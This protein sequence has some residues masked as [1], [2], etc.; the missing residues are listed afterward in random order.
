MPRHKI[1]LALLAALAAG[2]ASST[3]TPPPAEKKDD[4][5]LRTARLEAEE[6]SRGRKQAEAQLED[7][8]RELDR[9]KKELAASRDTSSATQSEA[10][11]S[12]DLLVRQAKSYEAKI[13]FYKTLLAQS[14]SK[15]PDDAAVVSAATTSG[16][17]PTPVVTVKKS[18]FDQD[19]PVAIID[20]ESVTR[21]ELME[22]LYFSQGPSALDPFIDT[23][24]AEREAKRLGIDATDVELESR[25]QKNLQ[26]LVKQNNGEAAL[27]AKLAQAGLTRELLLDML[28]VNE[29]RA[30]YLE[31]LCLL[32]RT[33]KEY[34]ER[35]E[36]KA[37]QA[38]EVS[39]GEKVEAKHFFIAIPEGTPEDEAKLTLE[40]AKK[41]RERLVHGESWTKVA[42][43][44]ASSAKVQAHADTKPYSHAY[45]TQWPELDRLF[46]QTP[47][48]EVS[49]PVRTKLGISIVQIE[50]RTPAQA[51]FEDKRAKILEDLTAKT[52]VT[53]DELRALSARLRARA[54]IEKK[55][56]LK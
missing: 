15:A 43:E 30:V 50:K 14:G 40:V 53:E 33:S 52:E 41:T 18:S 29:K 44:T 27:D 5:E 39:F 56:D 9:V 23:V 24:L 17:E 38:F 20:G 6:A 49:Q 51:K 36:T 11:M 4:A 10:R 47:D 21:R 32:D 16:T 31:K 37:L 48:G 55:L 12:Q 13:A 45:F 3:T 1:T 54:K 19:A 8:K 2:C 7:G 25:A 28:R 26:L 46:F 34:L 42:Q 35:L 22:F